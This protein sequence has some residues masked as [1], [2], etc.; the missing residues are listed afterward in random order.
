MNK[1]IPNPGPGGGEGHWINLTKLAEGID[2]NVRW[3]RWLTLANLILFGS[4][5]VVM[6]IY[7]I[8]RIWFRI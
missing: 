8:A 1:P 7:V 2:R 4:N 6:T 3:Y 5:A